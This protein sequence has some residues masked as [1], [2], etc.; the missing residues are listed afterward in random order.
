MYGRP[1]HEVRKSRYFFR[2]QSSM[3]TMRNVKF[4]YIPTEQNRNRSHF[5]KDNKRNH[6]DSCNCS[7][8]IFVRDVS[9]YCEVCI[10]EGQC[11]TGLV[12]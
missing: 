1:S 11:N 9:C 2:G 10:Q 5:N 3:C 7:N 8:T 12:K 6:E 4:K